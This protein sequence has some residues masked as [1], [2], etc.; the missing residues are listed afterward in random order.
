MAPTGEFSDLDPGRDG[1]PLVVIVGGGFGGL[2]AARSLADAPVDIVLVDRSNH[3]LFQPLLYQVAT[4]ILSEGEIA[5]P[6][7]GIFSHYPNVVVRLAEVSGFDLASRVIHATAAGGDR[8]ALSYDYLVVAAGA[9]PA[10]F[11]HDDWAQLAGGMKSLADAQ[12]LRSRILDAF[13]MA[14]DSSDP[15]ERDAWL[16]FVTVGGG[17]TGV[18]LTGQVAELSR[19]LLC[20]EF[21]SMDTG[22]AKIALLDAGSTV[23]AAFPQRLQAIAAGDLSRLGVEIRTTTRVT[24]IDEHGVD[25]DGGNGQHVRIP[26][27]TVF[28]A[29]GVHASGLGRLLGRE[30]GADVDRAGRVAVHPDCSLPGHPEVFAVGD[31]VSLNR[32]PG[33]AQPAI[34][35]GHYVAHTIRRRAAGLKGLHHRFHY[36]DKGTMATI[37]HRRAVADVFG[38]KFGGPPAALLWRMVHLTYLVGWGNRG[39][40]VSRWLWALATRERR[41]LCIINTSP[42]TAHADAGDEAATRRL[43]PGTASV[44]DGDTAPAP[45]STAPVSGRVGDAATAGAAVSRIYDAAGK[46]VV[47]VHNRL[48]RVVLVV[49]HVDGRRSETEPIH[50]A[51]A[52][53]IAAALQDAAEVSSAP[54]DLA[55][56]AADTAAPPGDTIPPPAT[57]GRIYDAVGQAAVEVHARLGQVVL[58]VSHADGQQSKSEP[59][60]PTDAHAI[61]ADLRRA[62]EVAEQTPPS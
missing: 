12:R 38:I 50:P 24:G 43:M 22:R 10:Y 57:A 32:L 7:R 45:D 37:G 35:E 31:M 30:A 61:A 46:A 4:G 54:V 19:Q 53:A 8:L 21:K 14:A 26:A 59:I 40:T 33:V 52:R 5:P 44:A 11:G 39:G 25:A 49:S 41:E 62:A 55:A 20:R 36:L 47:E 1:R 42:P 56:S 60:N 34:Q 29:A 58:I 2:A 28:W 27:R 6:L 17:P 16:T 9:M 3:H 13:E 48:D 18:E 51:D 23:L 15:V